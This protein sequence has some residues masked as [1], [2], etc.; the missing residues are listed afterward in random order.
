M[1]S[2]KSFTALGLIFK[3]LILFEL[4]FIWCMIKLHFYYFA[5]DHPAFL[6][7]FIFY[8]LCIFG[9]LGENY[10]AIFMWDYSWAVYFVPFIYLSV[11][12]LISYIC[13][14]IPLWYNLKSVSLTLQG[15]FLLN[16][17]LTIKGLCGSTCFLGSILFYFIHIEVYSFCTSVL[18]VFIK[19]ENMLNIVKYFLYIC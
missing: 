2:P 14:G 5:C 10:L 4:I 11:F 9:T 6:T 13:I 7:P 1:F 16:I 18:S 15:F 8:P 3:S 12:K 17:A 19:K